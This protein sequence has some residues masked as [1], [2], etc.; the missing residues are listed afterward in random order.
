M[1][2]FIGTTDAKN[3]SIR[4]ANISSYFVG[5][6]VRENGDISKEECYRFVLCDVMRQYNKVV[7]LDSGVIVLRDIAD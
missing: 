7:C 4:F 1:K 2:R 6:V 3:C 5:S